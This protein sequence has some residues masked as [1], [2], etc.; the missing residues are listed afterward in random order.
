MAINLDALLERPV[1]KTNA[2]LIGRTL[3]E[4]PEP[5]KG[6]LAAMLQDK[7]ITTTAIAERVT[8]AGLRGSYITI[9]RHRAN[10]C[11]C[12]VGGAA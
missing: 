11:S 9:Y 2:C 1:R 6:A 3:Q 4:L 7:T 5:Y 12:N 8:A 10:L